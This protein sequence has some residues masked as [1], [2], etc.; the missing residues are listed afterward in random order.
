[1][2]TAVLDSDNS[3]LFQPKSE[4]LLEDRL[5]SI[6]ER[7]LFKYALLHTSS[8]TG[9]IVK[10]AGHT[11]AG[12]DEE[13]TELEHLVEESSLEYSRPQSLPQ[14]RTRFEQR[15]ED[16]YVRGFYAAH[17]LGTTCCAALAY[18]GISGIVDNGMRSLGSALLAVAALSVTCEGIYSVVQFYKRRTASAICDT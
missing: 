13:E 3:P 4:N 12:M 14:V 16:W 6:L 7:N 2:R 18:K 17:V 5:I 8:R 1:M 10:D 9:S 11:Y 15:V